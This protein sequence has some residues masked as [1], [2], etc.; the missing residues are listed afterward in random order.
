ALI[1][2]I[3][4]GIPGSPI[5]AILLSAL[6]LHNIQ[7]G[8]LLF[9]T[10]GTFVWSLVAAYFVANI[11]MFFTMTFS[12]RWLAKAAL[13]NRAILLPIIFVCCVVGAYALSN[14]LWDV[15]VVVAFGLIGFGLERAKVPLGPFVIGF[16]LAPMFE[17]EFRSA[18]QLSHGNILGLF[19]RPIATS[20]LAV[21]II[22]LV[23][24]IVSGL[25]RR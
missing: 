11:L 17:S 8:P 13:V 6:I 19:E 20:F 10:N 7:P 21:S 25:R 16:V 12:V 5:D 9:L 4:M 18:L 23:W 15:W 22:L 14:R 3:T 1:P 24:P 2:L